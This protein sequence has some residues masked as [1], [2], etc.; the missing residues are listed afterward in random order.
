[1]NKQNRYHVGVLF[2]GRSG[3]HEV[4]LASARNVMSALEEAGHHVVP[5]GITPQGRWL[6]AGDPHKQL[7]AQ[8]AAK[9]ISTTN[10]TSQNQFSPPT[11]TEPSNVGDGNDRWALLP[12]ASQETT[13]PAIDVVFPVLHGPYG[14]DGTVQGLLEMANLPYVGCGVLASAVAMDKTLSKKIFAAEG[15]PQSP[16]RVVTRDEWNQSPTTVL[17]HLE[18]ELGYPLFVK[19]AN[20]GSSVG[21]S[22]AV[23]PQELLEGLALAANYDR[24]I[25]VEKAVENARELEVSVLGNTYSLTDGP[26]VSVPG[27]IV[28]GNEFYDYAAK[29]EDDNSDLIIPADLSPEQTKQVQQMACQAFQA[30]DGTGL[31]RVDFL[32]DD[33]SQALYLNEV[34]TMPGFTRISM[35]PKLWEASGISYPDL[36][37]RLIQLA[38]ANHEDR[39]Q[40]SIAR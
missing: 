27:E 2:G 6:T 19:P 31:A 38:L 7:S 30:I 26:L 40:N 23:D 24:K 28:P 35:Y 16:Y 39:Q 4:S 22:K 14:E 1:M 13:L 17:F 33:Q 8:I 11:R 10:G 20:L 18:Q 36:V 25:V 12:H 34:N 32:L 3:E 21:V 37:D 9:Q 5:L 29:Y 15:L